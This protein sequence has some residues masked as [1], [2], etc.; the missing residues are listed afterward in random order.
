MYELIEKGSWVE[1]HDI[2]LN[3]GERAPQVPKD[4]AGIALEM[5]VKGFLLRA[6]AIGE[7]AE[8]ITAAGRRLFGKLAVVN[9]AYQHGFGAPIPEL[10][11]IGQ[12]LR[13]LLAELEAGDE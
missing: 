7:E 8:I 6:A 5:R 3:A 2:V 10:S 11:T 12:E 1:I 9:P 13:T 4:T